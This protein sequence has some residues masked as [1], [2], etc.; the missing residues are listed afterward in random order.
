[1]VEK[2]LEPAPPQTLFPPQA[3]IFGGRPTPLARH[4]V[5]CGF[6]ALANA[7]GCRYQNR[8]A[9]GK[10]LQMAKV[11][12]AFAASFAILVSAGCAG[13]MPVGKAPVVVA[14]VDVSP[15]VTKG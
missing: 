3:V 1:M 13:K 9:L 6:C 4:F 5:D 14:P 10:G 11:V 15:V 12:L 8:P 2:P 7:M